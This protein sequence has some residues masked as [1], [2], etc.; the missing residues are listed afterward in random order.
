MNSEDVIVNKVSDTHVTFTCAHCGETLSLYLTRGNV[1]AIFDSASGVPAVGKRTKGDLLH[2]IPRQ[3]RTIVSVH[4]DIDPEDS[5][6]K[7]AST[8]AINYDGFV[9]LSSSDRESEDEDDFNLMFSNN[10]EPIV[11]SYTES[12]FAYGVF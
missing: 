2:L 5:V 12:G 6:F 3:L 10:I 8:G 1:Y 4:H 9:Q 7:A 11:G